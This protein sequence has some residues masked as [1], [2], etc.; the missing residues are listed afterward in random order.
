[1]RAVGGGVEEGLELEE[2]KLEEGGKKATRK[3]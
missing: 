1:M 2:G 3:R